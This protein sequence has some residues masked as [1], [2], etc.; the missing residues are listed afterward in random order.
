MPACVT[1]LVRGDSLASSMSQYL[2]DAIDAT[3]NVDVRFHTEV[4]A[5]EGDGRLER[6]VLRDRRSGETE[7][8]GAA[9][10]VVLIGA[11]PH[12]EWLPE[13]IERDEWG[14]ILTGELGREQQAARDDACPGVFAA[15]DVRSRSVK[16]VAG[17]VGDGALAVTGVHGWL[18]DETA[19]WAARG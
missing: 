11:L 6:L 17:A 19:R 15:G 10:L 5:A 7:P 4:A 3:P 18:V 13:A 16:R 9:A 1:I 2:L 8:V 14:Y 12:T